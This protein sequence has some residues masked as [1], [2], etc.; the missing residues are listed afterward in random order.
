[1]G[2]FVQIKI[3]LVDVLIFQYFID[4]EIH[5][6]IVGAFSLGIGSFISATTACWVMND[7]Y[8]KIYFDFGQVTTRLKIAAIVDRN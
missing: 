1:M 7:G 3:D 5:E 6:M 2:L 4:L 8:S